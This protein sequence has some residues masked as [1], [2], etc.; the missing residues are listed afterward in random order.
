MRKLHLLFTVLFGVFMA[1]A[2]SMN[3]Q[4][5]PFR[6]TTVSGEGVL[7]EDTPWYTMSIGAT[8]LAITNA[9]SDG[10]IPLNGQLSEID[11]SNLWCFVG[12]ETDGYH[13]YNKAYGTAKMLCAP[14]TMTGT[15]GSTSYVILRDADVAESDGYTA[16]WMFESSSDIAGEDGVYMYEKDYTANRVNNR[17]GIFA[18]WTGGKDSGS[19]LVIKFGRQSLRVNTETGTFTLSNN[20]KTYHATWASNQ[21]D[22]QIFLSVAKNNMDVAYTEPELR[23]Y[24]GN[25]NTYT[26]QTTNGYQIQSFE[27]DFSNYDS[28]NNMTMTCGSYAQTAVGENVAHL[29]VP[30]VD[31]A[32][33]SIVLTS[34][35]GSNG[36]VCLNN[37]YVTVGPSKSEPVQTSELFITKSGGIP[38]RI[39]AIATAQNGDLIAVSDYRYCKADIGNGRVDLHQRISKDN[40]ATW[41][42]EEVIKSGDG[43]LDSRGRAY[44][45]NAGYGDACIVADRES[46]EVLMMSVCGYQTFQSAT[47]TS[48]NPVARF[49]SHDNGQTWSEP[50]YITEL[51]YTKFDEGCA[52]GPVKSMFFGSGKIHQ[53]RYVKVGDYY[54]LYASTLVRDVNGTYCNY[55][56]YSDDFGENWEVLGD[57][58]TP[59]I[60]SGADEPKAEELPDGSVIV[61]S[62]INGGR[63]YNIFRFTD[64]EKAEGTWMTHAASNGSNSG[65]YAAGN[66]CNGEIMLVPAHRNSDGKRVYIALQSVPFGSGRTNVGIYYKE[67]A[68]MDADFKDPATFAA[69]WD[70][71]L[72]VSSMGS[73]YSTMSLQ[74]NGNI[75]FLYEEET[76]GASYTIVFR[77]LSLEEITKDAYTYDPS[78]SPEDFGMVNV[79]YILMEDGRKID[80][81]VVQQ[82]ANSEVS[83][84][85]SWIMDGYDYKTEGTVGST[86]CVITVTRTMKPTHMKSIK[87]R[88]AALEVGKSYAIFNTAVNNS[89]MRYGFYYPGSST[90]LYCKLIMPNSLTVTDDYLWTVED[91]GNGLYAFKSVSQQVY[92]SDVQRV[93][94]TTPMG[95]SVQE[96][97]TSTEA[98][99]EVKS[100]NEEGN[101]IANSSISV[102]DKVFTI[103][104]PNGTDKTRCWNGNTYVKG[105][106]QAAALWSNAHPFAFYEIMEVEYIFVTYVLMEGGEEIAR[107]VIEQKP[108]SEL[109]IPATLYDPEFYDYQITG[110]IGSE[111]SV[112]TLTRSSKERAQVVYEVMDEAGK[113]LFTSDPV[114]TAVGNVITELPAEY[115]KDYTVYDIMPLTIKS[116]DNKVVATA[117]F[118]LPFETFTDFEK[119]AWYKATIRTDYYICVDNTEPYY[120]TATYQDV[121]NFKWAFQGNPYT[122]IKIYNKSTGEGK[123][124]G[125]SSA[126]I[127]GAEKPTAVMLNESTVWDIHANDDGFV[128]SLP[129]YTNY[130]LNQNGGKAGYLGYWIDAKGLTDDG[131]TWRVERV[132]ATGIQVIDTLVNDTQITYDLQG[133]RVN[134]TQK[135]SIYIINRKKVLVK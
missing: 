45:L 87:V 107:M 58:S 113:I 93:L 33:A 117:T 62:R 64:R 17:S 132:D 29:A 91:A 101:I 135:G 105:D 65:V 48:P 102:D 118:N 82:D 76:Y 4:T 80:E 133:R 60:P 84:P 22:P 92:I 123:T 86:D 16:T 122:G 15:T 6:T 51:F 36:F 19:T 88:T 43:I 8:K 32:S 63:Y 5:L 12:D 99:S 67:L 55:V 37:F 78:V 73:A 20:A 100:L 38:Y 98:K 14:T 85:S 129:G 27:L 7:A 56:W 127:S 42:E 71:R 124:L 40:G 9:M 53:S 115:K 52:R 2:S 74:Q 13:I 50:E 44:S 24:N 61:S 54:R 126:M 69:N 114:E 31:D 112:I 104:N 26:L 75:A 128:F 10:Y 1:L 34:G 110:T 131:S 68:S 3:A 49:R 95:W 59:A 72:Q 103:A 77:S 106:S 47:R 25:A 94:S 89:E 90:A 109:N 108:N 79:T 23:L 97:T 134:Q 39:P 30:D 116:G 57:I 41:G 83:I 21:T 11:D 70:G 96:W 120:P 119:A 125:L 46:S 66:S 35:N 130:Y 121:D 111:N 81:T 28:S 18:F